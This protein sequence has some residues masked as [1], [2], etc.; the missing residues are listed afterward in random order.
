MQH[1][2][3][4]D[5]RREEVR[6]SGLP[7]CRACMYSSV[8]LCVCRQILDFGLARAADQ[9]FMMTPYVVTRYYRAPEVIV[10]MKYKENGGCGQMCVMCTFTCLSVLVWVC[11]RV[12]LDRAL[13]IER[14]R[15]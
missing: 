3:G 6:V 2:M 5:S 13:C 10:G 12:W 15:G 4:K 8:C 11:V 14:G 1:T 7:A 9:T